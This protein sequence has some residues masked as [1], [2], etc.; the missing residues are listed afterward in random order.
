MRR[1]RGGEALVGG[2]STAQCQ[3][4]RR[5][6]ATCLATG[7]V[8][9]RTRPHARHRDGSLRHGKHGWVVSVGRHRDQVHAADGAVARLIALDLRV[10][11]A[12]VSRTCGAFCLRRITCDAL[13]CGAARV[14]LVVP[15]VCRVHSSVQQVA[16]H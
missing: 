7:R 10:H 3:C 11:G 2:E 6:G 15:L 16:Y 4:P 14:M 13:A 5:R 8:E 12:G 9:Y 1:L